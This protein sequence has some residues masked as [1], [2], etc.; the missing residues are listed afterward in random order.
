M[1]RYLLIQAAIGAAL[2]LL[3]R[4][5]GAGGALAERPELQEA[6][7]LMDRSV[8][9]VR[10]WQATGPVGPDPASDPHLTGLIGPEWSDITTSVGDPA[11]KRT[12]LTSTSQSSAP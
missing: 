1:R 4:L 7:C 6:A 12:T 2:M 3:F 10:A 9:G 11:A 8:A 5:S